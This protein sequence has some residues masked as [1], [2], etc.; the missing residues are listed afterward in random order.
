MAVPDTMDSLG[1]R[2]SEFSAGD[3][4]HPVFDK[5]TGACVLVMHELPGLTQAF[6]NFAERLIAEGFHVFM[7]LLIGR[8]LKSATLNNAQ[9]LC[10]S[11]EFARLQAGV[12]APITSWLR[13]LAQHISITEGS[14]KVGV[15]GMCL[16]GA[17][18]I[19]LVIEPC[20]RAG[21]V[22][23]PAIPYS[24]PYRLLGVGSGRWMRQL[25]VSNEDLEEAARCACLANRA[26]S[27]R[28]ATA[29][30]WRSR[31]S[32]PGSPPRRD[33]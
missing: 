5:G 31:C 29:P 10:V 17:F 30:G 9:Q 12:S 3:I 21:V 14:P 20:V 23:Q 27:A 13:A 18:V 26:G 16:T 33:R 28:L 7:P 15:I 6:V 11:V 32:I 4:T 1:F 19:P 24:V 8:P 25:N 22:S 2:S